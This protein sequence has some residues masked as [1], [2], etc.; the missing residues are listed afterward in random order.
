MSS[1]NNLTFRGKLIHI[2]L[3][4]AI[5]AGIFFV[6]QPAQLVQAGATIVVNST[7]DSLGNDGKCTL[8]E[9]VIS[10][11][12]DAR[13]GSKS[14][15]CVAGNGADTIQ[16]PGDLGPFTLTRL[17]NGK[18]DASATGDL[19]ILGSVTIEAAGPHVTIQGGSGDRVFH[20]LSGVVTIRSLTIQGGNH[21][22]DGGGVY[23]AATLRLSGVTLTGNKGGNGGGILNAAGA[24]LTIVNSTISGNKASTDGGGLFNR[25]TAILNNVTISANIA[26]N[27][28]D[29]SGNGGGVATSGG[30]LLVGNSI[31]AGN[32]D[33]SPLTKYLDCSGSLISAGFNL[34]QNLDG[35]SLGGDLT[36][37]QSGTD[38]RLE[39]L[40]D[41]GGY[42]VT[43]AL[44]DG[45]PA[46]DA[47][48]PAAPGTS[49]A[50]EVIDQRGTS[51]PHGKACD[52]GAFE[53]GRPNSAIL[54]R[55]S[56][57]ASTTTI[58]GRLDSAP[59]TT[60]TIHLFSGSDI[61]GVCTVSGNS[62]TPVDGSISVTTDGDGNAIFMSALQT[63]V[64][65][66][67]FLTATAT[68]PGGFTS[69]RSGC[70]SVGA[71]NDSWPSA[72][73]L[74]L[75]G[76]TDR[77][78]AAADFIDV[79]GQSRWY[80]FRVEPN[81]QVI[82]TLT[83]LPANYDLTLYKDIKAAFKTVN[84][85]ADLLRLGA[86]F[87]PDAFTPDA[88]T[89]DVFS[90]DAFTPDAFTPDAFT[91][92]AFTPDAFTPDAFTPD[93]FTPDA[94]TPDAF[95]PD[96]FTP[97]A[98]T[99]DA[100]TPDAFTPD[101]FT[102]DAFTPDA[103]TS[104]QT[105]SL[106]AVSAFE[107]L[108]SEGIRVNTWDNAGEFYVRVRGRNG[109][110][111]PSAPFHLEVKL[112][113][114]LCT[115]VSAVE[116][117]PASDLVAS[118][119][120]YSTIVLTNLGRTSGSD[121]EK[122]Q[123]AQALQ[124]F[125]LRAEVAGVVVDVSQDPRVAAAYGQY[126][127]YPACPAAA[128][129][130]ASAIQGIVDKYHQLNPSLAY[131]VIVGDDHAIPFFRHPD[132]SMLASEKSYSPPVRDGSTSQ[133]SLRLGYVLSQDDYGA[134]TNI[135]IKDDDFPI[136]SLAVGR[137]VETASD[138]LT[139]L[140][141]YL[142]T[143]DGTMA[144]SASALVT[145][146]DFLEDAAR[147]VEAELVAGLGSS[148]SVD[149]LI[150]S[151][152]LAPTDPASWT[153]GD[154][155]Q[156]LLGQ[157]HDLIFL[158][159]HFSANS[160]LAA[161]FTT[162]LMAAELTASNVDLTN[163][164]VF[165][166]GCHAGYNI[167][168][169]HD[170]PGVTREPDWAQAFASKG[171]TLI[172]GTGYQYG[173]T[174]FIKY[175]EQLYLEFSRQL[176]TGNGPVAVGKALMAAKQAYLAKT[177]YLRGIDEKS[178]LEATLFG[179]PM[180]S[181][182]MPGERISSTLEPSA[183]SALNGYSA[184]PGAFL[185]LQYAD[186]T[187]TPTS[188]LNTVQLDDIHQPA[189]SAPAVY[190]SGQDGVVT[191]PNEPV[192]PLE[193]DNVSFANTVLRGAGF[194]GGVYTDI[195]DVL[196]LT[197]ASATEIRGVHM[198]FLSSVPFPIKPWSINYFDAL[199]NAQDGATRLAVTPAQYFSSSP[200]SPVGTLRRYDRMDFRLFYSSNVQ[201][202]SGN[203]TPALAAPPTIAVVSS[204]VNAGAVTF[205]IRVV[206]NPA[207]GIQ[208]VWVTYTALSGSLAGQ[209]VSLD[210]TQ[211]AQDSTLWEGTLQVDGTLPEDVRYIVQAA[212]G[213]GLVSM[214]ANQG[215]YYIPGV[216]AGPTEPT[217]LAFVPSSPE[218][219]IPA[220]GRYSTPVVLSAR[221]TSKGVPLADK[222]VSLSLGPQSRLASTD[223]DGIATVTLSIFGLPGESE[224]RASF[225]GERN[226]Q[227]SFDTSPFTILKQS[228]SIALDPSLP[229]GYSQ[230]SRLVTATL[231]DQD[232]RRLGEETLFFVVNGAGGTF[233]EA[234]I[235]DY[236]GRAS[237]GNIPLPPGLYNLDVY[238][239]G[240]IPALGIA[241]TDER[242]E[243]A[244]ASGM[245]TLLNH[246]P[247]AVDDAYQV[248]ED[249]T[250][251]IPAPGVLGNDS[252]S[253]G[254][255]LTAVLLS[256]PAH[257]TVALSPD[258]G[259]NYVPQPDFNG[260]DAFTYAASDGS[261][262][263][264]PATVSI[265]VN[266]VNE[267]PVCSQAQP[268]L[269]SI[270]P[271]NGKFVSVTLLGVFDPDG[272]PVS[273]LI[274]SVFQDELVGNSPDAILMGSAV[275]L[276]AERDGSGDGRVYHVF[277]TASDGQGGT[278]NGEVKLG[279]VPHDQGNNLSPI[280]GGP[281]YNSTISQ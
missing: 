270:W 90:P 124:A 174:D 8:R 116:G 18:E 140:N 75:Q 246:L 268:S 44:L 60:F 155:R 22:G 108:V 236:A 164:L 191:K 167:V 208:E 202:F 96:A 52:I 101:A 55:A 98:F 21:P 5:A 148:G 73:L 187:L 131:V 42:A 214:D 45:S 61:N 51:R 7:Q 88:F 213:V 163:A 13:S 9:A 188:T 94:F 150:A 25:G 100:F 244:V 46:I 190:L 137:L 198:P 130:V 168:N 165:S 39:P 37:N 170:V 20:V 104:A 74:S 181:I 153:A 263:S 86:E 80:K 158:A 260:S 15:E 178:L 117:L 122:Q 152:D 266:P 4:L 136:P 207:A 239:S 184:N 132:H 63:A 56:S 40:Q 99:P 3:I 264:N 149:S 272:N 65:R 218:T 273:V 259:F 154:L 225:A 192:L 200:S 30:S 144:T 177:P 147:Q 201:T 29:G 242:Y 255:P 205:R 243:A 157:R 276:R 195:P 209:W 49:G 41:N 81:S 127:A 35:C 249:Q 62:G 138:A 36:G 237:L 28:A 160:A 17:D 97:D 221:L 146:Y 248:D 143:P 34:I 250:L 159:G 11:N 258:G 173:D 169:S 220:S 118:G 109:A 183:V 196:A 224:A 120:G 70:V 58:T 111:N 275:N 78:A 128:N 182:N 210:L 14:N 229:S 271:V 280:D 281:L 119:D 139:V 48:S 57:D 123:L 47:G 233:S 43:H 256:D 145:G 254:Q 277:F 179:L 227:A 50:C 241:L 253:D 240:S 27:N 265:T 231:T 107:G 26:D 189:N 247:Q 142:S 203:S 211:N 23:N 162:R 166:A 68:D 92:D 156:A 215:E 279:V 141:A 82:V 112:L 176:R 77:R 223:A 238:F 125:S 79:V 222:T 185:G 194:R 278:C 72:T 53:A 219:Q 95:T 2:G 113:T 103:F 105:R 186:I 89:A 206:G 38:P 193:I 129:L 261:D 133:A 126:D 1:N 251:S 257:G 212:N 91:P 32:V 199:A 175:S 228:T 19:D 115:Q 110:F 83:G 235:T 172:A 6:G 12:K 54:I 10:A 121:Q 269:V 267:I 93:A 85:P 262:A 171:A 180:L 204:S 24:A 64:P 66:G 135:S 230:D 16:L 245:L 151:R 274:T 217:E 106:I 67:Q 234:L 216:V 71:G 197:G 226:Y 87:A 252:D 84:S 161:D 114:G 76:L 59:N 69:D 33:S 102:P 232:G 31:L 134:V